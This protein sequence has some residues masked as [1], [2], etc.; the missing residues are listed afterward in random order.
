VP[1]GEEWFLVYREARQHDPAFTGF[2]DWMLRAA[3][4]PRGDAGRSVD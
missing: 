4:D 3:Q 1:K 2:R